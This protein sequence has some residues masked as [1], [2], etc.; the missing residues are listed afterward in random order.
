[1]GYNVLSKSKC[2]TI[3][4]STIKTLPLHIDKNITHKKRSKALQKI[5]GAIAGD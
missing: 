5:G 4:V 3:G 2:K 1:M